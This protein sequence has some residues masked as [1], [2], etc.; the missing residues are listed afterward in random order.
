[1]GPAASG[2]TA[3]DDPGAPTGQ[4]TGHPVEVALAITANVV[5]S[6]DPEPSQQWHAT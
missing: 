2:A 3:E 5:V 1:M 4:E 6:R